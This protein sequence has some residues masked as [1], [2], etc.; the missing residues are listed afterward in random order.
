MGDKMVVDSVG[1]I[2]NTLR[3]VRVNHIITTCNHKEKL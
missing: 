2:E 3:N 1:K